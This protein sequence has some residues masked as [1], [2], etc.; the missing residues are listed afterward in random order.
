MAVTDRYRTLLLHLSQKKKERNKQTNQHTNTVLITRSG[1]HTD[2][3]P[4][5]KLCTDTNKNSYDELMADKP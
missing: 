2:T 3:H 4:H 5:T 1:T